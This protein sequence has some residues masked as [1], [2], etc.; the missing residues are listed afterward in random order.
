MSLVQSNFQR[1]LCIATSNIKGEI[2]VRKIDA[3]FDNQR[4]LDA[5][6]GNN[7]FEIYPQL[8]QA[9]DVRYQAIVNGVHQRETMVSRWEG[10]C[11][12]DGDSDITEVIDC[13]TIPSCDLRSLCER[14]YIIHA[15]PLSIQVRVIFR[16]EDHMN[17][18]D[19]GHYD[20]S[21]WDPE[22]VTKITDF[23]HMK[24]PLQE[25]SL[26]ETGFIKNWGDTFEYL[27]VEGAVDMRKI[28]GLSVQP[29]YQRT[30][31]VPYT[32]SGA[33]HVCSLGVLFDD[34]DHADAYERYGSYQEI[35]EDLN[36]R[37]CDA[38]P[39][40]S[41]H[42]CGTPV[43]GTGLPTLGK[44]VDI[45]T[46]AIRTQQP[47]YSRLIQFAKTPSS[48]V[49]VRV[50]FDSEEHFDFAKSNHF[51]E[52]HSQGSIIVGGILEGAIPQPVTGI[53]T[54]GRVLDVRTPTPYIVQPTVHVLVDV[55]TVDSESR[56]RKS[57]H[58]RA[59][60]DSQEQADAYFFEN[61]PIMIEE[62]QEFI[63]AVCTHRN[64]HSVF[65]GF[66]QIPDFGHVLDKRTLASHSLQSTYKMFLSVTD[67]AG[68]QYNVL[69]YFDN[70]KQ[71]TYLIENDHEE[72]YASLRCMSTHYGLFRGLI[73]E[74]GTRGFVIVPPNPN[75]VCLYK[76]MDMRTASPYIQPTAR[77][78]ASVNTYDANVGIN[79]NYN[80]R[81]LFDDGMHAASFEDKETSFVKL[82]P[83]M[84]EYLQET[85][86]S[87][88]P[89]A[90][91][92]TDIT[93]FCGANIDFGQALDLRTPAS[94]DLQP[95]YPV[96]LQVITTGRVINVNTYFNG[97][98]HAS[99]FEDMD[100]APLIAPLCT[101]IRNE[102]DSDEEVVTVVRTNPDGDDEVEPFQRFDVA[103]VL[104]IRTHD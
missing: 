26:P 94:R 53:Q 40:A 61:Q 87:R 98:L 80:V 102:Y 31:D 29:T 59:L 8:Q 70:E 3:L 73:V 58:I 43:T 84:M 104:D 32:S 33:A 50:Y 17:R 74:E 36:T 89:S 46:P 63:S 81:M 19:S 88:Y 57:H 76:V 15:L 83:S 6:E 85:I 90:T 71:Y 22:F 13:R 92:T 10:V 11:F 24:Y 25:I 20:E 41:K 16:S 12:S 47:T 4:H 67:E 55:Q 65:R 79:C 7:F 9:L 95:T 101:M 64:V 5:Y 69:G 78:N 42:Q 56:D 28:A 91:V 45:R 103:Q 49:N 2:N 82:P 21:P 14:F 60:F 93:L 48:V 34:E 72:L 38:F 18:C 30:I 1:K 52:L 66:P 51:E 97:E 35:W 37:V 68:S 23:I 62:V 75:N 86:H 96:A 77:V 27:T 54:F 39:Q 44:L 99:I 100:Y